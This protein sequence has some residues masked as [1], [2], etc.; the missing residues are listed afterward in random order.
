MTTIP[1][2]KS[3]DRRGKTIT[4][5]VIFDA[6]AELATI[7]EGDVLELLTDD[8]EPF[9]HDV[10]A[11][12]E[13]V[14]HKLISSASTTDGLCFLIEKGPAPTTGASLAVV[15]SSDGLEELLSPLGFALAAALEGMPVHVYVQGPAVR[16]L[17]QGFRPKLHGWAKPFSRFA[18]SGLSKAGHLPAQDKLRQLRGLGAKIY[19]CGPSMQHFRVKSDALIFDDLPLVEYFSFMSVMKEADVHIYA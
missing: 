10:A 2:T 3:L 17:V 12:C 13:T 11:W 4:T 15:I 8:F 16:V 6:A 1:V 7:R 5:F 9:T 19:M 18:A 14:G